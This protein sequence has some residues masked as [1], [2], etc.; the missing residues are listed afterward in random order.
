MI[1]RPRRILR[2][3]AL[4]ALLLFAYFY[5]QPD[6]RNP[7]KLDSHFVR[8]S[9]RY[10]E[11][12]QAEMN[13]I[14]IRIEKFV[15]ESYPGTLEKLP[16]PATDAQLVDIEQMVGYRLPGDLK[17]SLKRHAEWP[18]WSMYSAGSIHNEWEWRAE[19]GTEFPGSLRL[20]DDWIHPGVVPIAGWDADSICVDIE[21]GHILTTDEMGYATYEAPSF[22]A[23]LTR[24]ADRLESGDHLDESSAPRMQ[25]DI[26]GARWPEMFTP[27]SDIPPEM[28]GV[29]P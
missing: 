26:C 7:N 8:Q 24:V 2:W 11:N 16:L 19:F 3:L 20:D 10:D 28:K 9:Q 29:K 15:E 27:G 6:N 14:W 23:W 1:K 4:P 5:W 22:R 25:I 17:A 13:A 12:V 18:V 21:T